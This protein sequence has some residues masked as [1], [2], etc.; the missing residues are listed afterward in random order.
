MVQHGEL[1]NKE[2][3]HVEVLF[4]TS[5]RG[6]DNGELDKDRISEPALREYQNYAQDGVYDSAFE[7]SVRARNA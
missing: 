6:F 2:V 4:E 5:V 7:L 1:R 3:V